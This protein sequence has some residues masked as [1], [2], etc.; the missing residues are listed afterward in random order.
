MK[1][2]FKKRIIVLLHAGWS[3]TDGNMDGENLAGIL[4]LR[5]FKCWGYTKESER[6]YKENSAFN[7]PLCIINR[8][9]DLFIFWF[10][11]EKGV[12]FKKPQHKTGFFFLLLLHFALQLQVVTCHFLKVRGKLYRTPN[13]FY[14]LVLCVHAH[15]CMYGSEVRHLMLSNFRWSI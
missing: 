2:F 15:T 3:N 5:T 1:S 7:N 14:S 11:Q 10:H 13:K 6:W 9:L 8:N 12:F 4:W